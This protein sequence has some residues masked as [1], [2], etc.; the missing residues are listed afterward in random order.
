MG[1]EAADLVGIQVPEVGGVF[2]MIATSGHIGSLRRVFVGRCPTLMNL[3]AGDGGQDLVE[4]ALLAGLL[5]IAG[6][7]VLMTIDDTLGATYATWL[8][9]TTG[10]PSL[11]APAEPLTSAGGS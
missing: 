5:G 3:L 8:S 10:V 7:A 4:Y 9:P 6:W 11:W 2:A 1:S